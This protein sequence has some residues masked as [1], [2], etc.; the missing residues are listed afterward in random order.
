MT[1]PNLAKIVL[2]AAIAGLLCLWLVG[3]K[4]AIVGAIVAAVVAASVVR[5]G[6]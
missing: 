2:A 6:S 4:T 3:T 5:K 1:N